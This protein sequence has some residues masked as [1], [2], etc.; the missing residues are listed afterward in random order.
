MVDWISLGVA[1]IAAIGS[2][3][4]IYLSHRTKK[5]FEEFKSLVELSKEQR[6]KRIRAAEI[7]YQKF[8]TFMSW[9]YDQMENCRIGCVQRQQERQFWIGIES[10]S[11]DFEKRCRNQKMFFTNEDESLLNEI[12]SIINWLICFCERAMELPYMVDEEKNATDIFTE[13]KTD[14]EEREKRII[15]GVQNIIHFYK[16]T[17]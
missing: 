1:G 6:E 5:N 9:I 11:R 4:G 13:Q 17:S 14:F 16:P 8:A 2:G 12:D 15:E 10:E 3:V 7:T